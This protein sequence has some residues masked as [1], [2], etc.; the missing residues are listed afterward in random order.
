MIGSNSEIG[1]E[2]GPRVKQPKRG[3]FQNFTGSLDGGPR[4]ATSC[5]Q[6]DPACK[7]G[8]HQVTHLGG[9]GLS[10]SVASKSLWK[11]LTSLPACR[12]CSTLDL[13]SKAAAML[14]STQIDAPIAINCS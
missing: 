8:L 1:A 3:A 13:L 12:C 4:A 7:M 10:S 5:K 2:G 6:T 11:L 14:E 9:G